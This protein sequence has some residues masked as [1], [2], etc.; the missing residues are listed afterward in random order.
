M[1]TVHPFADATAISASVNV[2]IGTASV[3]L[4]LLLRKRTVFVQPAVAK[5]ADESGKLFIVAT[6][7]S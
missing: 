1:F 7:L 5:Y 6:A 4:P 3:Y 2:L